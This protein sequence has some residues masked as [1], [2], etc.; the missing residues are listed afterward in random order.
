MENNLWGKMS[1]DGWT[2]LLED[3]AKNSRITLYPPRN[4]KNGLLIY[5][6]LQ[7]KKEFD[8]I[9]EATWKLMKYCYGD[10]VIPLLFYGKSSRYYKYNITECLYY[11][12]ITE[13]LYYW[14]TP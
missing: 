11:L 5:Q 2:P 13:Y 14:G 4:T 3:D 8:L 7:P 10:K 1:F 12:V 6:S 9:N